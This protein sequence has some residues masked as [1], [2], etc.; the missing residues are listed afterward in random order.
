L[1]YDI[2]TISP[3]LV[4]QSETGMPRSKSEQERWRNEIEER[5]E[6]FIASDIAPGIAQALAHQKLPAKVRHEAHKLF[7]EYEPVDNAAPYLRDLIFPATSA[8]VLRAE[9]TFWEKATAIHVYCAQGRFRGGDR[10]ARHWHDI[11]RLDTAGIADSAIADRDVATAVARHKSVFFSEKTSAGVLLDYKSAVSGGL[12]LVPTDVGLKALEEDYDA[13]TRDR[14]FMDEVESF[15][16]L[17]EHCAVIQRKANETGKARRNRV[18]S[19]RS[20]PLKER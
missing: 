8:T 14:L 15:A 18:I 16:D 7:I 9:R 2:R 11:A 17:L 19:P 13:M 1:T 6:N 12:N 10:F 4:G 20:S 5:L 3:D